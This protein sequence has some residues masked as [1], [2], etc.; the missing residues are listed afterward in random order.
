[1]QHQGSCE[2]SNL[3][4]FDAVSEALNL[5]T[6]LLIDFAVKDDVDSTIVTVGRD[7][8]TMPRRARAASGRR[9]C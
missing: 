9:G 1:V 3:I 6:N 8:G 2:G 4:Y 7:E 5:H